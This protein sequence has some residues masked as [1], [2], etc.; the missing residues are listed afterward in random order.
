MTAT[1][2]FMAATIVLMFGK[3]TIKALPIL[4]AIGVGYFTSVA[5]GL[6][7]FSV[8]IDSIKT[9]GIINAPNFNFV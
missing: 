9:A 3:G 1:I 8:V 6:V 4:I 7:D 2:T 5:T